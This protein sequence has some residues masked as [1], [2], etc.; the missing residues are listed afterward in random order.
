M[1]GV[2]LTW[3]ISALAI[4]VLLMPMIKPPWAKVTS[5]GFIDFIRRYWLHIA[6]E[7]HGKFEVKKST[8]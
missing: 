4:G 1:D 8:W 3:L 7:E 6:M 2:Y 5:E